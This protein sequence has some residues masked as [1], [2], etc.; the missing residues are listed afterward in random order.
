VLRIVSRG[1]DSVNNLAN[2]LLFNIMPTLIDVFIAIGYFMIAFNMWFGIITLISVVLYLFLTISITEW[3]TKFRRELI[4][5]DNALNAKAVDSLLNFETVKYFN[6]EKYEVENY[7]NAFKKYQKIEWTS[8]ATLW[9]LNFSQ[10]LVISAALL[11]GSLYCG[12]LIVNRD[13][14]VG[15]YVLYVTY[16]TQLYAPLNWLG[17]Y[18]RMIQQAF[19]D[20]E[21]MFDLLEEELD[22]KDSPNAKELKISQ[23]LVEFENVTFSYSPE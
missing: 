1:C 3:R 9:I 7:K 8:N 15:D 21:S 23:G 16:V 20:M 4:D 13:L 5:A 17:T 19:I 18:Y 2:Y 6:A 12:W 22:I 11:V 14:T 10:N